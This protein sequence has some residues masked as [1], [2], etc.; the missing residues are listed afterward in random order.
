[1]LFQRLARRRFAD[2]GRSACRLGTGGRTVRVLQAVRPRQRRCVPP[3]AARTATT[4]ICARKHARDA[5]T[6]ASSMKENA[7]SIFIKPTREFLIIKLR[8]Y[9][10]HIQIKLY[11]V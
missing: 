8:T 7:V 9:E 1:M 2:G 4:A 5:S 6:Y 3:Q 10:I 11:R